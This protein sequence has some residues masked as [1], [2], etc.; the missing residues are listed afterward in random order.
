MTE[1]E[2]VRGISEVWAS[3][4][5]KTPPVSE[6]EGLAE[7]KSFS[8][9][10]THR[11]QRIRENDIWIRLWDYLAVQKRRARRGRFRTSVLPVPAKKMRNGVSD[12]VTRAITRGMP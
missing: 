11:T 10:M 12:R 6:Y 1:K 4:K 9:P 5:T 7:N 3:A 2:T 8:R